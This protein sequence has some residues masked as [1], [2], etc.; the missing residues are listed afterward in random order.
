LQKPRTQLLLPL[1]VQSVQVAPRT[2]HAVALV[3]FTQVPFWQQP[4]AQLATLQWPPPLDP[5]DDDPEELVPEDELPL[6]EPEELPLVD[7]DPDPEPDPVPED[8]PEDDPDEAPAQTLLW[9]LW[10]VEVQSTQLPPLVP[11]AESSRPVA[12][13]PLLSQQPRQ[14]EAQ[15][16]GASS[17]GVASSAGGAASSPDGDPVV[18]PEEVLSPELL[19][20]SLPEEVSPLLPKPDDADPEAAPPS[21]CCDETT[22]GT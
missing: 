7:P 12:Q 6:E 17:A 10:P 15:P 20:L 1:A 3:F 14:K 22:G 16:A 9:Q 4:P 18:L 2:P 5:E 11:H 21:L 19:P 8:D 13:L